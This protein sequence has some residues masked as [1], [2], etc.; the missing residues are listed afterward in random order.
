MLKK[1]LFMAKFNGNLELNKTTWVLPDN[2][3]DTGVVAEIVNKW[4]DHMRSQK[5]YLEDVPQGRVLR[6]LVVV[7]NEYNIRL[8]DNN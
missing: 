4:F 5:V 7:L 2:I 6:S 8:K 1:V 3:D